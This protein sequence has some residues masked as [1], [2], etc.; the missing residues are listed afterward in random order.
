M[1][2][3][4]RTSGKF[5]KSRSTAAAAVLA[6][7]A[8]VAFAPTV[9]QAQARTSSGGST[10]AVITWDVNAQTAIYEVARQEPYVTTRSF[11]MVQG[12]VYDAVNAIAGK[13]YEPYLV[14][15]RAGWGDSA[16]AAV[17]SA[18]YRVLLSLFPDQADALLAQY[19]ASLAAVPD[20][21]SK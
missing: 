16:D 18:A 15:P 1:A 4:I 14:A 3:H 6:L 11:A 2:H 19:D 20:G 5:W 21:R 9:A 17:A 7:I 12:A 13:P 8:P 10:N